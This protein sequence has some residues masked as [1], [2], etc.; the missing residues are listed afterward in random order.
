MNFDD[1]IDEIYE[2]LKRSARGTWRY[3]TTTMTLVIHLDDQNIIKVNIPNRE[4][5][6]FLA[7]SPN[8]VAWLLESIYAHRDIA[9]QLLP[10]EVQDKYMELVQGR[11]NP[12][13][14]ELEVMDEQDE[15]EEKPVPA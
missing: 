15:A 11:L 5:G 1:R 7:R 14:Q 10:K 9:L 13:E 2:S 8:R 12:T 6:S 4:I 3:D